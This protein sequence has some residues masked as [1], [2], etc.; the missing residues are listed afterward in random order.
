M[1]KL[2]APDGAAL[3]LLGKPYDP[4]EAVAAVDA[5]GELLAGRRPARVPARLELFRD[6][7]ADPA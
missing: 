7:A 4:A 3:G 6:R 1:G 2:I 5:V